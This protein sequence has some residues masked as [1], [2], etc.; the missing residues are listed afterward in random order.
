MMTSP[1]Q[2]YVISLI[3]GRRRLGVAVFRNGTLFYYAG[4]SLRQFRSEAESLRAVRRMLSK[5]IERY[6]I[7]IVLLPELNRQ[8]QRAEG[9]VAIETVIVRF[10]RNRGVSVDRY[11]PMIARR[12]LCDGVKP[13]KWETAIS[14]SKRYAELSRFTV[15]SGDWQKRYYGY[16]FG[17]IAGGEAF[18]SGGDLVQDD[19]GRHQ[20]T[21]CPEGGAA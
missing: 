4:K 2:D 7:R 1:N 21:R 19:A 20:L 10:M 15:G 14:L 13:T 18:V 11:D 16:V 12:R 6:S 5:L 9:V 3:P 8:Q 17:A